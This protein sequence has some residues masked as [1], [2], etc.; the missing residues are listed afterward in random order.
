MRMQLRSL[1][2]TLVAILGTFALHSAAFAASGDAG[3]DVR[4]SLGASLADLSV[5]DGGGIWFFLLNAAFALAFLIAARMLAR[6]EPPRRTNP[7][8]A[9]RKIEHVTQPFG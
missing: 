3:S 9:Y 7:R 1:A 8:S 5:D 2:L 6:R 4:G